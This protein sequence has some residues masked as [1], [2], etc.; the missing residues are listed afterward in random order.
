MFK[1][2]PT[3]DFSAFAAPVQKIIDLNTAT[4][5]KAFELQQTAAKKQIAQSQASFKAA[6]SI[7]DSKGL[8][9]FVT[10]QSEVAKASLEALKSDALFAATNT[11]SYF[12]EV[13]AILAESKNAV[14]KAA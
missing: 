10:E 13:Q 3:A 7:K 1:N 4:L 6:L 8:T 14:V 12:S 11:K 9:S 2:L 5:T